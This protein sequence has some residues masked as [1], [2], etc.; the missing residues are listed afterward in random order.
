MGGIKIV[1]KGLVRVVRHPAGHPAPRVEVVLPNVDAE[2][3]LPCR[4]QFTSQV[5]EPDDVQQR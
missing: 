5:R 3:G 1:S 2:S 4:V